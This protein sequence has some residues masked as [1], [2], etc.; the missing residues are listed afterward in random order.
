MEI[1]LDTKVP[2]DLLPDCVTLRHRTLEYGAI[3]ADTT[4]RERETVSVCLSLFCISV[5][6]SPYLGLYSTALQPRIS[7]TAGGNNRLRV[8]KEFCIPSTSYY[9]RG[10]EVYV[11]DGPIGQCVVESLEAVVGML[12]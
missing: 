7:R 3:L 5:S 9:I 10:L 2:P 8:R 1:Y 11:R 12:Q 6:L 4:C